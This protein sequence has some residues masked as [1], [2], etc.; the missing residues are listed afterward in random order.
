LQVS[1]DHGFARYETLQ[2]E[3]NLYDREDYETQYESL[4][5]ENSLGVITYYSLAS[6]FLTGKYRDE[7]DLNKSQRGGGVK[8]YLNGHGYK[9]LSA[10]D[11]VAGEHNATPAAVAVA[12]VMARPG[13]TAPIASA[14]SVHQLKEIAKAAE[15]NLGAHDIE[16]LTTAS[17]Y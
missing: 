5:R 17:N 7:A 14:T 9:I 16:L 11:K 2:P 10:L 13:I 6:G 3:Y 8:K 4:C 1:K 12:W 15:L